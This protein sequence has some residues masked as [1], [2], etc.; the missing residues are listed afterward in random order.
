MD[1]SLASN[2][3]ILN[4]HTGNVTQ[5]R[6]LG[7]I[8]HLDET[9]ESKELGNHIPEKNPVLSVKS[10]DENKGQEHK[11]LVASGKEYEEN[12][13]VEDDGKKIN[14]EDSN[15]PQSQIIEANMVISLPPVKESQD[16]EKSESDD[17][18]EESNVEE[19]IKLNC[20]EQ[21]ISDVTVEDVKEIIQD[22]SSICC[23]S[24]TSNNSISSFTFPMYKSTLFLSEYLHHKK[25]H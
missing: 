8:N 9:E 23:H 15:E 2:E 1:L 6:E 11:I 21:Y 13:E 18:D 10:D 25:T 19:L 12:E 20:Q 24:D 14:S 16:A 17:E 4:L 5:S 22:D 7:I 3:S